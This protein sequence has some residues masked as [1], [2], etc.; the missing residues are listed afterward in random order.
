MECHEFDYGGGNEWI[1]RQREWQ[2]LKKAT[3]V[4]PVKRTLEQLKSPPL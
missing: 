2:F 1:R 3:L 4:S